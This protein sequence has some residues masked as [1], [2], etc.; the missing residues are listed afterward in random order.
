[1]SNHV[2]TTTLSTH[3]RVVIPKALRV[4]AGLKAGTV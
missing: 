4:R 1:M 3:G 2:T